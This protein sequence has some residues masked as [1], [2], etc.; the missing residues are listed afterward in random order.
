LLAFVTRN[1]SRGTW[2]KVSLVIVSNAAMQNSTPS[3]G[4][5]LKRCVPRRFSGSKLQA[6]WREVFAL[7]HAFMRTLQNIASFFLGL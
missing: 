4:G 3:E 1:I 7:M 6:K 5:T 2:E